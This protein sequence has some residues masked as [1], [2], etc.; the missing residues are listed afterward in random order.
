MLDLLSDARCI[1]LVIALTHSLWQV[2][3][4]A[5]VAAVLM[6]FIQ[7]AAIRYQLGMVA[8]ALM[9]ACPLATYSWLSH[10]SV[11]SEFNRIAGESEADALHTRPMLNARPSVQ[12]E[13][14][15]AEPNLHPPEFDPGE[16]AFAESST[17]WVRRIAPYLFVIYSVGVALML[18]RLAIGIFGAQRIWSSSVTIS[19]PPIQQ[20]LADQSRQ[21]GVKVMPAIAEST[22]IAVPM[23]YGIIRPM[24]LLPV[25]LATSLSAS[26]LEAVLAHELAHVHRFDTLLIAFQRLVET[27]LFFHPAV[28]LI[29][30]RVSDERENCCDDLVVDSG[31]SSVVYAEALVRVAELRDDSTIDSSKS[32]ALTTV[33]VTGTTPSQLK[34]RVQRL[35]NGP[36]NGTTIGSIRGGAVALTLV[37]A[38]ALGIIAFT[39]LEHSYSTDESQEQSTQNSPTMIAAVTP[40]DDEDEGKNETKKDNKEAAPKQKIRTEPITV[41]GTAF[42]SDGEPI[43]GARIFIASTRYVQKRLGETETDKNGHYEFKKIPLPIEPDERPEYRD[44]GN[45]EIFGMAKGF[46]FSW[47]GEKWYCPERNGDTL[48]EDGHSD[49]QRMFS[50][51]EPIVQ[52]LHFTPAS[53]FSGRIVDQ[54]GNPIPN[55]K[56]GLFNAKPVPQEGYDEGAPFFES[57]PTSFDILYVNGIPPNELRNRITDADGRFSFDALPANTGFRI[58]VK[59]PAGFASRKIYAS[60]APRGLIRFKE[61]EGNTIEFDGAT[62]EFQETMAVPIRVVYGDS[63]KPAKNVHVGLHNPTAGN[64]KRTDKTGKVTLRLPPG[65]YKASYLVEHK[66]P[67]ISRYGQQAILSYE[68]VAG[69]QQKPFEIRLEPA[70]TLDIQIVDADTKEPLKGVDLWIEEEEDTS[71]RDYFWRSWKMPRTSS[72]ERPRTNA[73]GKMTVFIKPGTVGIGPG[74]EFEPRGYDSCKNGVEKTLKPGERKSLVLEMKKR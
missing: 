64:G 23:V 70:A 9:L 12:L 21:I 5:I 62:I 3:L 17:S 44:N 53:R 55:T 34:R 22:R 73:Q 58:S 13:D 65:K 6:R 72:V 19:S 7:R 49:G 32:S 15:F 35:L 40:V 1:R 57:W 41:S 11:P 61:Y 2:T 33:A 25:S 63:G 52:D 71:P 14:S 10:D 29:S 54:D 27:V 26:Q 68:V 66:T 39:T 50:G 24:I 31:W 51:D 74:Y 38:M 43:A 18:L 16:P 4:V 28:W 48:I 47:R 69:K 8:M 60:T 45:F 36:T 67:Y 56:I 46:G 42:D 20:I 59:P 30:N 37:S